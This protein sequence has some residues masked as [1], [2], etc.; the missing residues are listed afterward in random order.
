MNACRGDLFPPPNS[1]AAR[2]AYTPPIAA[3]PE[4][5]RAVLS[6]KLQDPLK[7]LPIAVELAFLGNALEGFARTFDAV[8]MFI[9][10]QR[11]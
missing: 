7:V 4:R 5:L 9:A 10:F 8:L 11:Q 2:S 3:V 6:P 1:T